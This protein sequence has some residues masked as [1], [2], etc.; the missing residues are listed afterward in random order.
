MSTGQTLL[1]LGAIALFMYT[2]VN[3]NR[4]YVE[5]SRQSLAQQRGMDTV[6]YAQSVVDLMYAT[7]YDQLELQF[8]GMNNV[9][10]SSSRF[11]YV[12]ALQDTIY[13]TVII[14]SEGPL[15]Q[16]RQGR[17]IEL[18]VYV[19]EDTTYAKRVENVLAIPA[20]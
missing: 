9:N 18:A 13:A 20:N 17:I 10:N 12:T 7:P 14:G 11:T 16:G 4:I 1:A 6:N 19:R 5:A 2:T 3:V 8:G 15:I